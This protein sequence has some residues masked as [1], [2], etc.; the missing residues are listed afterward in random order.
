[1]PRS[2]AGKARRRAYTKQWQQDHGREYHAEWMPT[3]SVIQVA[4]SVTRPIEP[5]VFV[6]P[7]AFEVRPIERLSPEGQERRKNRSAHPLGVQKLTAVR[8]TIPGGAV[9]SKTVDALVS[10]GVISVEVGLVPLMEL[11]F[12]GGSQG[13]VR[14]LQPTLPI[15]IRY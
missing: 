12:D 6:V 13:K 15:V 1:M 10:A 9:S 5:M 14:D 2:E 11:T 3:G 8:L 4:T 7:P